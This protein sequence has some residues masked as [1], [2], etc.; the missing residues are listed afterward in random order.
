MYKFDRIFFPTD[1]P[2]YSAS[3]L[4]NG[5]GI[6]PNKWQAITWTNDDPVS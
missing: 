3:A 5:N 4:V 2:I 6:V 1:G